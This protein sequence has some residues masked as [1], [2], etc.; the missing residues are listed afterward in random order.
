MIVF[1]LLVVPVTFVLGAVAVDA[2]ASGRAS[3]AAPRRTPTS[4]HSPARTSCSTSRPAKPTTIDAAQAAVDTNQDIND[5][6]SN[7]EI[8]EDDDVEDVIVDKTCFNSDM[9]DSVTGRRPARIARI[10][11][12]HL[13]H[14]PCAGYRRARA[15]LH[16]LADRGQGPAAARRAGDRARIPTA[17][18]PTRITRQGPELPQFRRSSAS[19]PSLART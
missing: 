12:E 7:A 5:E 8:I 10:L 3:G 4:P 2:A 16:G 18:S 6:G 15:R 11:L 13:R 9:L 1:A 14:R 17:S 19:S